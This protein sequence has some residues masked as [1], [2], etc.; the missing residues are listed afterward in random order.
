MNP[1]RR[2][3]T[4]LAAV[5]LGV[6]LA[7]AY[8]FSI[9]SATERAGN[10]SPE[11]ASLI[12]GDAG[13]DRALWFASPHQNL[14]ALDERVG[15]LDLYLTELAGLAGI[16]RPRLPSFG[17]FTVPPAS[18][19]AV[20]WTAAGDGFLVAARIAPPIGWLARI[21]GR[22]AGNPWL[23]GGEVRS[24]GKLF[25]VRWEQGLW[26]VESGLPAGFSW[27]PSSAAP[28]TDGQR[29]PE[30]AELVLRVPAGP[31][32]SGRYR[33]TREES[34]LEVRSGDLPE[35]GSL[36]SDW[37][38]PGMVLW[39]SSA[40][41]A[42]VGGPGLFLVWGSGPAELPRVAVLQRG[43]GR[44]F[45]LPG[46]SLLHFFGEGE[47][48]H[49]LGWSVRATQKSAQREGLLL[50]P[51][52][53]RHMARPGGKTAWLGLA[54][55]LAPAESARTLSQLAANLERLPLLPSSEI[56]R[57]KAAARLLAPFHG[58]AAIRFEIWHDPE[59]ARLRLCEPL[60]GS[61]LALEDASSDEDVEID[62]PAPIR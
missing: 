9:F 45:R 16:A 40:D 31:I 33:L 44:N 46:E 19:V 29:A 26:I 27:S 41:R 1:Q 25:K 12:E 7:G 11:L 3:W 43:G 35:A 62:E 60:A 50:V 28:D 36:E 23:A 58:C 4:I 13:F 8:A 24:S 52:L 39:V 37:T 59:G 17:P 53:E 32:P 48:A 61:P 30:I 2:R 10:P 54:G 34:G 20:G 38:V 47:A 6:G 57:L 56:H 18:E 22:L 51:W 14:G 5:A 15:D 49:R 21:A 55:R 42:P